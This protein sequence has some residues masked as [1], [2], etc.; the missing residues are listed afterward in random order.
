MNQ[1]RKCTAIKSL[2]VLALMWT[3]TLACAAQAAGTVMHLSGPLLAKKADGTI[4]VLALRSAVEP[5]D[6]LVTQKNGYAQIGFSD[7]SRLILQPDTT[8]TIDKF[9]YDAAKPATDSVAFTLTQGGVRSTVG[10]L[11][12]R[13]KDRVALM[14]PV[15]SI[16][17][18]GANVIV[19]YREL[20]AE[21][22]A[23]RQAY[24]L[25]STAALDGS[26]MVTRSDAPPVVAIRPLI[27]AQRLPPGPARPGLPA[28]LY[29]QVL[30]GA[31]QVSNKGGTMNLTAGQFGFTPSP[32]QPPVLLPTNPGIK[33]S[34]PPTF[35]G[36]APTPAG[37]AGSGKAGAVDCVVR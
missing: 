29:V 31:I 11:G 12:K 36:I 25:A 1:S 30:D 35:S 20:A 19:Q 32:K 13:S 6:T 18:Q 17:L 9:S 5:G 33:F 34:P 8:L 27:L 7:D 21:A 26:L 28:G 10:L 15:A 37:N 16:D 23:A 14:T 4:R 2:L 22:I 3:G 24:L